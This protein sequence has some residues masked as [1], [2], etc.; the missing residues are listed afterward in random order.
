MQVEYVPTT[1]FYNQFEMHYAFPGM[2]LLYTN[3]QSIYTYICVAIL[4]SPPLIKDRKVE[5]LE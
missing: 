1:F 3:M 4:F 2:V 5:L